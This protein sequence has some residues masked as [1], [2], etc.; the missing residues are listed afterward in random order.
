MALL[1]VVYWFSWLLLVGA[2]VLL[3]V[4]FRA[5]HIGDEPRCRQCGYDLRGVVDQAQACPECGQSLDTPHAIRRGRRTRDWRWMGVAAGLFVVGLVGVMLSARL[6]QREQIKP[7]LLHQAIQQ[8]NVPQ[9]VELLEANPQLARSAEVG[10]D[11]PDEQPPLAKAAQ[12]GRAGMVD[13]LL[14]AGADPNVYGERGMTALHEAIEAGH[15]QVVQ[16]LLDGGASAQLPTA[17]GGETATHLAI[18][19]SWRPAVLRE[20]LPLL[21][22]NGAPVNAPDA[23]GLAPLHM[24]ASDEMMHPTEPPTPGLRIEPTPYSVELVDMLITAG[25]DPNLPGPNGATP[26]HVAVLSHRTDMVQ[27]LLNFGAD[28]D[29]PDAQGD[30]PL[31]TAV[32]E[33]HMPAVRLLVEAGANLEARNNAFRTPLALATGGAVDRAIAAYLLEAGARETPQMRSRQN[34]TDTP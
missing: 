19:V 32:R 4:A 23:A 20:I 6:H 13:A 10:L 26:L 14:A 22:E 29:Q 1:L 2:V 21:L 33:Q 30:T 5:R 18:R 34:G 8:G 16:L 11:W 9:V 28:P 12:A 25:A 24:V 31:H 17:G 27:R 15:V 3:I 7:Y